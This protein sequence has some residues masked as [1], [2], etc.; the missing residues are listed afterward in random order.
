MFQS[1][2][3]EYYSAVK[4][5]AVS[6]FATAGVGPAGIVLGA[7]SQTGSQ[8]GNPTAAPYSKVSRG[9]RVFYFPP[10]HRVWPDGSDVA[11]DTL[12]FP[13]QVDFRT[14]TWRTGL[15]TEVGRLVCLCFLCP[16][17]AAYL[18]LRVT[19]GSEAPAAREVTE[20]RWSLSL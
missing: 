7:R 5:A 6:P 10:R 4:K 14:P 18:L 11:G 20:G 3:V 19:A 13:S 17:S 16:P 9:L 1:P 8:T 15:Q 12:V 2:S